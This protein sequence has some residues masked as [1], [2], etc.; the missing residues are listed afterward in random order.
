M[1][2]Y[3]NPLDLNSQ[4]CGDQTTGTHL[5]LHIRVQPGTLVPVWDG[6]PHIPLLCALLS[7]EKCIQ[8]LM[9]AIGQMSLNLSG[10]SNAGYTSYRPYLAIYGHAVTHEQGPA[11]DILR[12]FSFKSYVGG[13]TSSLPMRTFG[14]FHFKTA[15]QYN[16]HFPPSLALGLTATVMQWQ[17]LR[18]G[19]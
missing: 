8:S 17:W 6:N 13:C 2:A 16:S 1:Q 5:K 4:S 14:T 3:Q 15:K 9:V 18:S 19:I 11:H 12:K 10:S 7:V